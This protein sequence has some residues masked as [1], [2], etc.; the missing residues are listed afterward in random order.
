MVSLLRNGPR[1]LFVSTSNRLKLIDYLMLEFKA[2]LMDLDTIF[3]KADEFHTILYLVPKLKSAIIKS[4]VTDALLIK[5]DAVDFL[6][7]IHPIVDNDLIDGLRPA[8]RSIILRAIGDMDEIL[9]VIQADFGGELGTYD[10]CVQNSGEHST[11]IGLTDK[12]LNRSAKFEDLHPAFLR[13]DD[14]YF[15]LKRELK[16]H[17]FGYLNTGIESKKW[18]ELDIRIFDSYSAFK[19]HYERL[20]EVLDSLELGLILGES[21]SKDYPR[22]FMPVEVYSLRFFTF[23]DPKVIKRILFGLEHLEDGTRVVDYDVYYKN[24]KIYW[25]ECVEGKAKE[26]RMH[27]SLAARA[28]IYERLD[29]ATKNELD[30]LEIAILKSRKFGDGG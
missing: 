5:A 9:K 23:K 1:M 27:A 17:A 14:D 28:E 24:K 3:D 29:D 26:D 30:Q 11:I 20:V 21:W 18:H 12:P 13:I 8:P 7:Q 16:M 25:K 4:D 2:E 10:A 22:V 19:I 15:S 6:C